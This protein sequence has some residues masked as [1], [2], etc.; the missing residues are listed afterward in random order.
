MLEGCCRFILSEPPSEPPLDMPLESPLKKKMHISARLLTAT[1][2]LFLPPAATACPTGWTPSPANATW[3]PRCYLVPPERSTSFFRC[4]DLCKEHGGIPACIGSVEENEFVTA[5]LVAADGLWLGLY[6]NETGFGRAE[7]WDRC[8]A[9][10]APSFTNW[11]E[12]QPDDYDGYQEDCASLDARTG[13][14]GDLECSFYFEL[15]CLCARGS[16]SAAFADDLKALEAT[17]A[18][19]ERLSSQ[20][21]LSRLTAIAF[22]TATAIALLPTLL[23][24]GRASWRRLRRGADAEPSVG[25][26][27]AATSPSPSATAAALSTTPG[28]ARSAAVKGVLRAARASTAGRRLRVSFVM[29]QA[30]WALYIA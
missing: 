26:Q 23:L 27:G 13:Q 18:D 10:D 19:D 30:G 8:V 1:A 2:T 25:A 17:R 12:G 9:G 15:S 29:G 22:T 24:L 16:A 20:R 5:K 3:G 28:A 7:G 6:Q 21:V 14:W 11:H 4:V